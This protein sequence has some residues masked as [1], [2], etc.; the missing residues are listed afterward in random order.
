MKKLLILAPCFVAILVFGKVVFAEDVP[1]ERMIAAVDAANSQ[2]LPFGFPPYATQ[3]G[4]P[5]F[6]IPYSFQRDSLQR[7]AAPRGLLARRANRLAPQQSQMPMLAPPVSQDVAQDVVPPPPGAVPPP[8]GVARRPILPTPGSIR[9][10]T[11]PVANPAPPMYRGTLPPLQGTIGV[12][13]HVA[14][15]PLTPVVVQRPTPIRNFMTMMTAPRPYIGYDPYAG[16]PPPHFP[17]YMP[18]QPVMPE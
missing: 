12:P 6:G 2:A 1:V 9:G 11:P 13:A 15:Q 16:T 17:I 18:A 7:D 3:G 5:T 10:A 8:P 14:V 4:H